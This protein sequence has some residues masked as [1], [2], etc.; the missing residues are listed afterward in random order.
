MRRLLPAGINLADLPLAWLQL[1]RQPIRYLVAVTGI[2]FAALLMYMQL[3]FQ[4]G[5]LNSATTFYEALDTDLILISPGTLN[6]GNFQ[7]FPQS[8]LYN[9]LGVEG[10]KQVIPIYVANV[11]AQ[12]LGGVK[13]T[14]LR[15]IG[16]DPATNVLKL[17]EVTAQLDKLRI[18]NYV[19]FDARGNRNTGPVAPAVQ[20]NGYQEM[21]LSDFSKTFRIVGLFKLGSIFAADSNLISSDST[22]IN[23]AYRQINEGEISLGAVRLSDPA[24]VPRVQE[25]LRQRYGREL[26]VLTKAELISQERNYWNTSSSFG[27]IFGFGTIMG[28]LVGGVVVYQVLYTDVT[29]HLKEYATLKA[30]GFSD[31]FL[32]VIVV[33]EAIILA[34]S[35][36]IP[37]TLASA[38]L[39]AFLT[40]ASGI[41]IEMSSDKILLVGSLTLGVCAASSA[42][43]IRKLADADPASVF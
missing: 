18:P 29:D 16:F 3:G 33:Q 37:A 17:P 25:F 27:I 6:S 31:T 10:V 20:R 22:A 24:Q 39:Y 21:L 2:G 11:N 13:P 8:L 9:A 12:R 19:L 42:I 36:F 41:R 34:V 43:A 4:S 7:Q 1:K 30:M 15:L 32:L 5:L 35:A 28:I 14:S 40:S 38:A 23:L 26:Q